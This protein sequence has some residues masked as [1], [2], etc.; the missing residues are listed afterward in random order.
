MY[1][2]FCIKIIAL[3]AAI[4]NMKIC[5]YF[6]EKMCWLMYHEITENPLCR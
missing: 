3:L 2:I 4:H 5:K 6:I 1:T